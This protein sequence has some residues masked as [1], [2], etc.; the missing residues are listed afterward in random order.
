MP[1]SH[2][3]KERIMEEEAVR[4]EGRMKA[5]TLLGKADGPHQ[6]GCGRCGHQPGCRGCRLWG[7]IFAVLVGLCL[8]HFF[9]GHHESCRYWGHSDRGMMG[10]SGQRADVDGQDEGRMGDGAK[11]APKAAPKGATAKP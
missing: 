6:V 8:I 3:E 2:A 4:M 11:P 7:W 9:C 5:H 1:L 10:W